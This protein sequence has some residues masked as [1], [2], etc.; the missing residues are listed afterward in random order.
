[1]QK[2]CSEC[3]D[4]K[5]D[6]SWTAMH[7]RSGNPVSDRVKLAQTKEKTRTTAAR[8]RQCMA[9]WVHMYIEGLKNLVTVGF[10]IERVCIR[11]FCCRATL[12]RT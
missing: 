5:A 7:G 3:L 8:L 9:G 12:K 1:M 2:R 6:E 10:P 11:F 4:Y